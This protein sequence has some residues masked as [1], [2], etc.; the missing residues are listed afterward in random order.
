M[1]YS[2]IVL[3]LS[4]LGI[5]FP[6]MADAKV[7]S[8]IIF[9]VDGEVIFSDTWGAARG[10]GRSHE[11]TD[12]M[13]DKHV[14][15]L[16]AVDGV[17]G[18]SPLTEPSYGWI[19]NLHGDDG[20]TYV[21]IHLNNDNPGTD[22]GLGGRDQAIAPGVVQGARVEAGEVIGWVGDS[23]NAEWIAPHLHFEIRLEDGTA[24]NSYDTLVAAFGGE[25][26]DT[27]EEQDHD[28]EDEQME[29]E[30]RETKIVPL[31]ADDEV[32]SIS[33]NLDLATA[34]DNVACEAESLI[35]STESDTVY[36]CG[37]N[38]KRYAFQNSR[39]YFSWYE[40]FNGVQEVTP[41]SLGAVP[42]GGVVTYKPG[43]RLVKLQ[44]VPKVYAVS[45][46]GLLR[47]VESAEIAEELF[48]P[49]WASHVDDLSD[50]F[51]PAYR[52]GES[53]SGA[54]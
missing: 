51:F 3:T 19:I 39:T 30:D 34:T 27:E 8:D 50:A 4:F 53:V 28:H 22:D 11:G 25:L 21:Y 38:G 15:V 41:E 33:E 17:I 14:P 12:I 1:K 20:Y 35:S 36:Y 16:A 40:D 54:K 23:G 52:V 49:D 48:G 9:P 47:W 44:T 7:Y 13:A 2:T 24:V 5:L 10:A 32:N 29:D 6:F 31:S 18:W 45:R 46:N 37:R 26:E 42:F 43:V